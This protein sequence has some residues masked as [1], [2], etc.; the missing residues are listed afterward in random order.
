MATEAPARLIRI[1]AA[2]QSRVKPAGRR[3]WVPY[4][5]IQ[6][7]RSTVIADATFVEISALL[8]HVSLTKF[9][10][11]ECPAQWNRDRLSTVAD[12]IND[13]PGR[14]RH[15]VVVRTNAKLKWPV[16]NML[17]HGRVC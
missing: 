1:N 17:G 5:E 14:L 3:P 6:G 2:P 15:L 11:S 4:C 16:Q 10:V 9:A 7:L 13:P 12:G 8:E